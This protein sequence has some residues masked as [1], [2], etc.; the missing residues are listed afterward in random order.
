MKTKTLQ[1]NLDSFFI[2]DNKRKQ[3]FYIDWNKT[4]PKATWLLKNPK[5]TT[6]SSTV[7]WNSIGDIIICCKDK[8]TIKD[9]SYSLIQENIEK[10]N[11]KLF[12]GNRQL[13]SFIKSHLQKS[14][15]RQKEIE[16]LKS[17]KELLFLDKNEFLRRICII[18]FEDVKLKTYFINFVWLMV[19]C[20]KG[21]VLEEY[22]LDLI[23]KYVYD[24]TM[25]KEFDKYNEEDERI[26]KLGV[27]KFIDSVN[28][29]K[30]ISNEKK[31]ILYCIGLRISYGG[32]GG[33]LD[34]LCYYAKQYFNFFEKKENNIKDFDIDLCKDI[35]TKYVFGLNFEKIE[36]FLCQ[37]VDFHCFPSIIKDIKE[38][39]Q[40][41]YSDEQIKACIW[42]YNS[43][44]NTRKDNNINDKD[45]EN[46]KTIW[47]DI[48]NPLL[49]HQLIILKMMLNKLKENNI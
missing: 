9:D 43:K 7:R 34:M 44:I 28:I 20:S 30:K 26:L 29:N 21:Y 31:D 45:M 38:D 40:Y 8:E 46:L 19:A 12:E 32:M 36:D 3:I 1:L 6:F 5:E 35:N 15:R 39:T 23:F 49:K 27:D 48:K 2:T 16:A 13:L 10:I 41:K 33:D 17:A 18:M 47:E 37:G 22:H 24:M 4:N 25:E 42:E 11:S 14:I